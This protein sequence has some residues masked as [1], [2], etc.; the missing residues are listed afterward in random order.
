MFNEADFRQLHFLRTLMATAG[1]VEAGAGRLH[2]SQLGQE[3]LDGDCSALQAILF[4]VALWHVELASFGHGLLDTWPQDH[5]GV[6]LWSLTATAENWRPA[7]TLVR[8]CTIPYDEVLE[9]QRD[10]GS[11]VFQVRILRLL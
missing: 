6:V 2:A 7:E 9:R 3:M 8:L 4:H 11:L 5:I 1:L 10:M